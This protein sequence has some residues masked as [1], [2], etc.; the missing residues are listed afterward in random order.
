M[1]ERLN[2]VRSE[3]VKDSGDTRE[4][5]MSSTRPYLLRALH[6][7]MLDNQLTPQLVIDAQS[8]DVQ[9]PRQFVE[10]G[11][12]ILNVSMSAV[13]DLILGNDQVE[14]SA[15]FSGTPFQVRVP[16][17]YVLAIIARENGAGMSFPVE[18]QQAAKQADENETVGVTPPDEPDPSPPSPLR[19][20]SARRSHLNVVK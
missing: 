16:I 7:W 18:E 9:V 19:P 15:R 2:V 11:R 5:D 20:S 10:D 17:V 3:S 14:F 1:G 12:I 6:E 4:T 8:P 13:R